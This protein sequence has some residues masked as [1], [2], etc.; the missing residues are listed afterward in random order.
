MNNSV[1]NNFSAV[2]LDRDG[3][4]NKRI[5]DGY[6][7]KPSEFEFISGSLKAL[8][9]LSEHF[10]YIL[11]VTNQQGIAKGLFSAEDLSLI[12]SYMLKRVS[13]A[14]GRI[15][16]IYFCEHLAKDNCQCRKPKNGMFIQALRDFPDIVISKSIMIGDSTEDMIFGKTSNLMTVLLSENNPTRE[17]MRYADK[18]FKNL[19]EMTKYFFINNV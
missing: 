9:I 13:D 12:H 16:K 8:K 14:G 18:H 5:I 7:T 10:K 3:V 1:F 15:D 4:I 17:L 6:V 2:F 11:I 19:M